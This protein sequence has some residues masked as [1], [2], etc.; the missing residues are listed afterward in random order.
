M[1]AAVED[2]ERLLQILTWEF[3]TV[4]PGEQSIKCMVAFGNV[5]SRNWRSEAEKKTIMTLLLC[6]YYTPATSLLSDL[7]VFCGSLN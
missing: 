3:A 4:G 2:V 5:A 6:D 7:F 1:L